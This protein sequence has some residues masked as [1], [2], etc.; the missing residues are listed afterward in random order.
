MKPSKL[1]AAVL[2]LLLVLLFP[3]P[4]HALISI[5]PLSKEEA[6]EK[7]IVMKSRPDGYAG[8][9][10]WLE[11]TGDGFLKDFTYVDLQ[12]HDDDGGHQFSAR[13]QPHPVVHGQPDDVV[14]VSFSAQPD[15][16][17]SCSFLVVAYG[18]KLGDVG[19]ELSVAKFLDLLESE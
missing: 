15:K 10:V 4:V 18:S 12:V 16:L 2:G 9:K 11:F 14:A 8:I 13:L 7:G 19:Y 1:S 6:K 3:P 17:K 5:G